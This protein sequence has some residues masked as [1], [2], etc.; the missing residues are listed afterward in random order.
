MVQILRHL[1]LAARFV[2]G[3]L[4]QISTDTNLTHLPSAIQEDFTALHAWAEVY[5]PGAGW[6]GLD[7]TSGLF[8]G[9]GHIPLAC[10]PNPVGA[11]PIT[12]TAEKAETVFSYLNTVERL[13]DKLV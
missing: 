9:E 7:A 10:T 1:G 2:S 6:I 13:Q 4:V 8:A 11:A 5:I 3:Y 12:G